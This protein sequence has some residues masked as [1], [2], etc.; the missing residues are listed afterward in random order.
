MNTIITG[1]TKGIGR[2]LALKFA[3]Q[4]HSLAI[5]SRNSTDLQQLKNEISIYTK[6]KY[7]LNQ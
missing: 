4:G 7:I 5:C 6:Q 2:A 1:A 3:S